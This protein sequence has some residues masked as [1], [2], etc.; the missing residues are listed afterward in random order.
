VNVQNKHKDADMFMN[1]SL[2]QVARKLSGSNEFASNHDIAKKVLAMGSSDFPILLSNVANKVMMSA[3]E[4]EPTTYQNWVSESDV[5]DFKENTFVHVGG[6]GNYQDV[7]EL[8]EKKRGRIKESAEKGSIKSKGLIVTLSREAIIND[9]L[10]GF[11]GMVQGLAQAGRRTL[12]ADVYSVLTGTNY[13][14]SDGKAIF[15]ADHGNLTSTGT[16][17]STGS[18]TIAELLMMQQTGLNGEKLN[19]SPYNLICGPAKYREALQVLN[20]ASIAGADINSGV[21]NTWNGALNVI[22]DGNISG[23]SWYLTA[24]NDNFR[25]MFLNG[26]GRRPIIEESDRSIAKGVEFTALFDYGIM[27]DNFRTVYKNVGA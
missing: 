25:V 22:K 14:M 13:K 18:L 21:V 19:I 10:G 17:I 11:L 7:Y 12:N 5:S 4:E 1:A 6:F 26:T 27:V 9:D 3:W 2:T 20:S 23:N 8:G 16:A 24:R 15:H